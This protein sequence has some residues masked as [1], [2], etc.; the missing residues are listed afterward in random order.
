M[1]FSQKKL[2][3]NRLA[4]PLWEFATPQENPRLN[5]KRE[6]YAIGQSAFAARDK[7]SLAFG[8]NRGSFLS[9]YFG[10]KN[11]NKQFRWQVHANI[12]KIYEI[13]Q[14]NLKLSMSRETSHVSH[15]RLHSLNFWT[16]LM[17]E[18]KLIYRS[19]QLHVTGWQSCKC[20]GIVTKCHGFHSF[21]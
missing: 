17:H 9:N 15:L 21:L 12:S 16:P 6:C 1:Q 4:H 2:Q 18:F 11:I 5:G 20:I 14:N 10:T 7:L 19:I 3:S 8:N 13:R